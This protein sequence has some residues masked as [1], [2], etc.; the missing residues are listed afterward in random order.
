MKVGVTCKWFSLVFPEYLTSAVCPLPRG[1][2]GDD[3][4][5]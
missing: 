1:L 2:S 3:S 4:A 5:L